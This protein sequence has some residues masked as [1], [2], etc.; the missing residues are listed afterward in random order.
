VEHNFNIS[1]NIIKIIERRRM[2]YV[3]YITQL[4]AGRREGKNKLR[5]CRSRL[6]D[7]IKID[8]KVIRC[9]FKNWINVVQDRVH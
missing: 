6:E 9:D 3:E 7:N 1:P 8:V 4:L 2:I 5:R